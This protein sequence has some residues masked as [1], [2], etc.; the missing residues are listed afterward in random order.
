MLVFWD[1]PSCNLE[2]KYQIFAET[3]GL[4]HD[5]HPPND[6]TAHKIATLMM[7]A[8]KSSVS[9]NSGY[10]RRNTAIWGNVTEGHQKFGIFFTTKRKTNS[11]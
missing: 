1:M 9:G 8:R 6:I 11:Y 2:C 5:T 7:T 3:C 4:R 10:L